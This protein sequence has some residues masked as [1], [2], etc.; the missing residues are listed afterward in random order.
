ML[1]LVGAGESGFRDMTSPDKL[2]IQPL[3]S[4][5]PLFDAR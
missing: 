2:K 1:A 3:D 4:A 5:T